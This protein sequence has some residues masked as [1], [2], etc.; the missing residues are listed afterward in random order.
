[1]VFLGCSFLGNK[2]SIDPTATNIE[3]IK[4]LTIQNGI[5]DNLFIT[6]STY[7]IL[8][9]NISKV[10]D[11]DTTMYATFSGNL[12]AGNVD[13]TVKQ[14]S[15]IRI[16][17]RKQNTFEW[18][19]LFEIPIIDVDSFFFERFD[20]YAASDTDYDYASVPVVNNIEGNFNINSVHSSFNGIFIVEKEADF[21]TII[22]TEIQLERDRP[23]TVIQTI[24]GKYP[25]VI[26]N[27]N[28][29]YDKGSVFGTFM[30]EDKGFD[31]WKIKKSYEYRKQLNDFLCNGKPKI[32]KYWDGRVWLVS[33]TNGVSETVDGHPSNVRSS[34]Q[35]VEIGDYESPTD[36]FN[37]NLIDV[38]IGSY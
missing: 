5:Y 32:L 29:N 25:F 8:D 34:F 21:H 23:S 28:N 3:N 24:G 33:I 4:S 19:T 18:L 1:M 30:E 14:V 11:Y 35:W 36:L 10:W 31:R 12:N 16:K 26:H 2:N 9:K 37:N 17:R 15:A 13:Y 6:R 7:F 22:E 38:D 27:S 20:K